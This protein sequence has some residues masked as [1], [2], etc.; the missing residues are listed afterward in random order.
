MGKNEFLT[1]KAIANR[2][3]AKGLQ[4][5]RWYCQM[6]QKQ[7]RDENGFKCHCM[8]ESHQRQMEVFGQN[9][10]RIV[11]GYSEEFEDSFLEHMKRSH[12]FSRVAATVVYNEYIA[13]RH[14]VHMNST[15]WATLTDFVK[16]LGRAGKCK[17]E[18]TP[19]GW[20]I[21]YIDRDSETLF[22]EKMKNKRIRADIAEE[23]KQE[24][25]IKKQRERAEQLMGAADENGSQQKLEPEHKP[26]QKSESD[27]K[28][29]LSLA[30]SKPN[31]KERS[32]SS[33]SVFDVID[34]REEGR[35]DTGKIGKGGS[36]V[37]GGGS[38]TLDE[39]MREQERAKERQNRKDYWLCEGIIV[40]VMS[41]ALA[42]KGYYKQKGVVRKVID[43]Y[44]GEIEIL[45]NKHVLRVDQEELETVIP[46]IGGLVRIVNGAYRGSNARLLSIDTDKFAAKVQIEKGIYDGKVL[47]AIEYEDICKLVQ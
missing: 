13:D 5:L 20:F 42:N 6:C 11:S 2:I 46:Q 37:S 41:K 15:Q 17:V 8:S 9:P 31:V 32:E 44:V 43:K 14:H 21:T 19:K 25:E 7:C 45:E 30:S 29:K 40:K 26:L 22:K 33:K 1:P 24:R 38:S 3:K 35:K 16:H 12:R 4:K 18:E 47:K 39:L 28:I 27:Q 23:E 34:N 36:G 10:E